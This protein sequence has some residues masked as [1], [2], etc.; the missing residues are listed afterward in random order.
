MSVMRN[1]RVTVAA[2]I[3]AVV[4]LIGWDIFVAV[5]ERDVEPGEGATISEVVLGFAGEHPVI[6]LLIGIVAGH[7]CWPQVRTVTVKDTS[8]E[9]E[10]EK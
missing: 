4:G 5:D 1:K 9:T 2:L 10:A 7:L 6:P 8:E 3:V